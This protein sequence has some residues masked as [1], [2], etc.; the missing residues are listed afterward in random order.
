MI[1]VHAK[2]CQLTNTKMPSE[3]RVQIDAR[4]GQHKGPA[5][6]LEKWINKK[7][8]IGTPLTFPDFHDVL[9]CVRDANQEDNLE[10]EWR[11]AASRIQS[12]LDPAEGSEEL[13]KK[14]E[15]NRRNQ[16]N[17]EAVEIGD[18]EADESPVETDDDEPT[19][20]RTSLETKAKR[21]DRLKRLLQEKSKKVTDAKEK[22]DKTKK[23][24]NDNSEPK[25]E[26]ENKI[27]TESVDVQMEIEC[28]SAGVEK[29]INKS[30][31][32]EYNESVE[33]ILLASSDEET[34]KDAEK[35][36]GDPISIDETNVEQSKNKNTKNL[37]KEISDKNADITDASS[38]ESIEITGAENVN[39]NAGSAEV[40]SI[41]A[42]ETG[43]DGINTNAV[44]T[45]I[46]SVETVEDEK[47]GDVNDDAAVNAGSAEVTS[48]AATETG[49]DD[50][51]TNA[52]ETGITPVET[53]EDEKTGD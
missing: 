24:D 50:I 22:L 4:P 2:F 32:D 3:P 6:R 35:S 31:N 13:K 15:D 5:K 38:M 52:V 49:D 20:E 9:R 8:P 45:G 14:L 7:V 18:K 37:N 40:T 1:R 42:T 33:D 28:S 17:L 19:E 46:T 30:N 47:T 44:E 53:V 23:P 29:K 51:N 16:L 21:K 34:N 25:E 10:N 26:S 36:R 43:D 48:I 27:V 12:E 41:A 39:L 11:L